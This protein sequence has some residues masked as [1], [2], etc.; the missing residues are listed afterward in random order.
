MIE[1]AI[2]FAIEDLFCSIIGKRQLMQ[3]NRWWNM[4]INKNSN[5]NTGR[6]HN[7]LISSSSL[8]RE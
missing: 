4:I 2:E 5:C 3:C 1:D 6:M 7:L 8:L